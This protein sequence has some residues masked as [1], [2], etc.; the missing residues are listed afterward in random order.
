VIKTPCP[1]RT[2]TRKRTDTSRDRDTTRTRTESNRGRDTTNR[3]TETSRGRE[4][5]EGSRQTTGG[6]RTTSTTTETRTSETSSASST[7]V[8]D[9]QERRGGVAVSTIYILTC[10]LW[11]LSWT[12]PS[13]ITITGASETFT[14]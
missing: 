5:S 3:Q 4:T 11:S 12:L 1:T 9:F 2:I 14:S 10:I 13:R 8:F 7:T 6:T